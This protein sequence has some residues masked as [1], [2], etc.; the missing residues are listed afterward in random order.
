MLHALSPL[1]PAH[2][3]STVG[4]ACM[5]GWWRHLPS[6]TEIDSDSD[7]FTLSA[8]VY[9]LVLHQLLDRESHGC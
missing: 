7:K 1:T 6:K 2:L 5:L 4:C 8:V 3:A 9:L